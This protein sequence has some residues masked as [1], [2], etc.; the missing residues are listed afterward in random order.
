VRIYPHRRN[1]L[2]APQLSKTTEHWPIPKIFSR[3][4]MSRKLPMIQRPDH[5]WGK[6]GIFTTLLLGVNLLDMLKKA[7]HAPALRYGI[8]ISGFLNSPD[9]MI[10]QAF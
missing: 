1:D 4:G 7:K 3:D 9:S 2:V 6:Y 10:S 8:D 5:V